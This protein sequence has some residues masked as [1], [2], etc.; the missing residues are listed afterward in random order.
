MEAI[1]RVCAIVDN[2]KFSGPVHVTVV[3][4]YQAVVVTL[5]VPELTIFPAIFT[6]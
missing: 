3:S 4:L 1:L 5:L 2:A 6:V